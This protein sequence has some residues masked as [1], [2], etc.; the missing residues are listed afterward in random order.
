MVITI[1]VNCNYSVLRSAFLGIYHIRITAFGRNV[2]SLQYISRVN[3][4]YS[5]LRSAFLGIYQF[6]I[7]STALGR[8]VY[9]LHEQGKCGL[10]ISLMT[11]VGGHMMR[12]LHRMVYN[13][14]MVMVIQLSTFLLY[15]SSKKLKEKLKWEHITDDITSFVDESLEVL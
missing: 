1:M 8:N 9:S 5:V 14:L 4:N 12:I 11:I 15:I 2:Y 10:M 3:L 6:H 13:M 7:R